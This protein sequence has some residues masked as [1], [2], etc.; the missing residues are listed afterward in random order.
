MNILFRAPNRRQKYSGRSLVIVLALSAA[1]LILGLA[2]WLHYRPSSAQVAAPVSAESDTDELHAAGSNAESAAREH[3]RVATR[4]IVPVRRSQTEP[5]VR[6]GGDA[7]VASDSAVGSPEAELAI[8]HLSQLEVKGPLNPEQSA[9]VRQELQQLVAQGTG[10]IPAIHRFLQQNP[11]LSPDESKGG[12]PAGYASLRVGLIDAL[13]QI[14]G[15]EAAAVTEQILKGNTDPLEVALLTRNL[16]EKSPGE[17]RSQELNAAREVLE[18]AADG[19]LKGRDMGPI[20]EVLQK[21]GDASVVPSLQQIAE[22][23]KWLN[24]IP[25]ELAELPDGAGVAALIELAANS[26]LIE[27]DRENGLLRSLAQASAEHPEALAALVEQARLKSIP[28]RA[29][30]GIASALSGDRYVPYGTSVLGEKQPAAALSTEQINQ[31]LGLVDQ[32]IG[33][34]ATPAAAK[35][36]QATR[37]ALS[38]RLKP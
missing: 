24:Y 5:T 36:L 35:S 12:T 28:E 2:A 38:G 18:L 15:P 13:K 32:L 11:N 3:G 9:A 33:M 17:F 22:R 34:N 29:W 30:P 20:L 16:E 26:N 14:G 6:P 8:A 10:A 25:F 21:Y 19:Q 31:R 27:K 37:L 23:G 4:S 7:T 1:A